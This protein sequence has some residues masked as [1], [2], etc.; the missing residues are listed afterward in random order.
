MGACKD[1][2]KEVDPENNFAA[3]FV[4]NYGTTTINNNVILTDHLWEVS[5][6]NNNQLK[7][8]YTKDI[9][10]SV[11]GSG[12]FKTLETLEL[13]GVTTTSGN[14]FMI[15]ET[16]DVQQQNGSVLKKKVEGEGTK[17]VNASGV[18]QINIDLKLTDIAT[19]VPITEY[20]EFKKK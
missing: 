17:T 3:E 1:K 13:V 15:N 10:V 6:V 12:D 4:G 7:I 5:R 8:K 20:L 16:V 11:P 18:Q 2:D 14:K 9:T 19:G